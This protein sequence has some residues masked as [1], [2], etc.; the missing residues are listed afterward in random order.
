[1]K[2]KG[3]PLSSQR[4]P[5]QKT[6]Q[7]SKQLRYVFQI[8]QSI[9]R[10]V[11][12]ISCDPDFEW[13]QPC[14]WACKIVRNTA[15]SDA[16]PRPTAVPAFYMSSVCGQ[17]LMQ[18]RVFVEQLLNPTILNHKQEGSYRNIIAGPVDLVE[19]T[20][21]HR[22]TEDGRR[23]CPGQNGPKI[24]TRQWHPHTYCMQQAE[25]NVHGREGRKARNPE[26][27]RRPEH[28]RHQNHVR[29]GTKQTEFTQPRNRG[30]H[31]HKTQKML[32]TRVLKQNVV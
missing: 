17:V 12:R 23:S 31:T 15:V 2:S 26:H 9:K 27:A 29:E 30:K 16:V 20:R 8:H 13:F 5:R 6:K 32:K 11:L 1:M 25:A 24:H 10:F 19:C 7:S 3:L 14:Q 21:V 4:E 18:Q 28:A 22:P